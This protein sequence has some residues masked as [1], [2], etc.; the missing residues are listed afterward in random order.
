MVSVNQFIFNYCLLAPTFDQDIPGSTPH[1]PLRRQIGPPPHRGTQGY[2]EIS[3]DR[4]IRSK[5]LRGTMR[6]FGFEPR[7]L[8]IK[9]NSSRIETLLALAIAL[10][11][12]ARP[13]CCLVSVCRRCLSDVQQRNTR[14]TSLNSDACQD[15]R[16]P[17][18]R[19]HNCPRLIHVV[20]QMQ[21]VP[22][23]KDLCQGTTRHVSLGRSPCSL[24]SP[25]H[26]PPPTIQSRC[27]TNTPLMC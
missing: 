25:P 4:G 2:S 5:V 22:A 17:P 20:R 3:P 13:V 12:S 16:W 7:H 27:C 18:G 19:Q 14:E 11:I 23:A 9:S 6:S 21:R 26:G 15:V 8:F 24:H 1:R 10:V